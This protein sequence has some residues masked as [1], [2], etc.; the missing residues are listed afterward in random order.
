MVIL[1]YLEGA[2]LDGRLAAIYCRNDLQGAWAVDSLGQP[3][4]E[5]T[6]GGI[7]QREMSERLGVNLV[8]YATCTDYKADQ[9]HVKA[10]L[11][12]TW[13]HIS[14]L[15]GLQIAFGLKLLG[16]DWRS[17]DQ[18]ARVLLFLEKARFMLREGMIVK[19]N[20]QSVFGQSRQGQ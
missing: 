2:T 17:E 10:L 14:N 8:L 18:L 13:T 16:I 9:A 4:F 3:Q 1:D 15:N 19:R 7:S 6:P 5:T 11:P 20:P 12:E